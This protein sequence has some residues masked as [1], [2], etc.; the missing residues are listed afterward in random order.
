VISSSVQGRYRG[1][2]WFVLLRVPEILLGVLV[3]ALVLFLTF[4]VLARYVLDIGLA[5]SDEAARL[6]FV[7]LVFLGF[8]VGLK[9]RANIGV[10]LLVDR[11]PES[12]K[13]ATGILQDLAI[14][15]FSVVFL[16]ESAIAVKFS[17][18]QRLPALQ[19]SIAWMYFAVLVGSALM[20]IYAVSNFFEALR[21]EN[22]NSIKGDDAARRAN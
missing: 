13:R 14:L 5:W 8:A 20:T 1:V 3:A 19:I 12:W 10:E 7:W 4:S 18:M 16:W 2:A 11:C 17:F 21:G 6:L 9:H 22:D 15:L